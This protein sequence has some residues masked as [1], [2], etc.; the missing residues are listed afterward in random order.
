MKKII[1]IVDP[2]NDFINGSLGVNNAIDK[3]N[4][5]VSYLEENITKYDNIIITLDWHPFNHISFKENGGEWPTHCV[6][7]SNGA[8]I[9]QPIL[10]ILIKHKPKVTFYYKGYEHEQEAYSFLTHSSNEQN[11]LLSLKANYPNCQIDICGIANEYCVLNT[12]KDL[13][14]K[15]GLNEKM[16]ILMD[17]VA[18]IKDKSIL[19]NYAKEHQITII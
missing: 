13:T 5:L 8:A 19:E 9:Y 14:E 10:D 1:L 12:V 15:M 7:N 18:E 2:Q 11:F 3:M 4:K 6:Q 16:N 17:Y